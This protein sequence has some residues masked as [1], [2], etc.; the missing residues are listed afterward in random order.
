MKK[1][2]LIFAA[3]VLVYC[4][5]EISD[6]EK[7]AKLYVDMVFAREKFIYNDS[8]YQAEKLGVLKKYKITEEEYLNSLHELKYEDER[9]AEFFTKAKTYVDTLESIN[10]RQK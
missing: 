3:V 4:K 10:N 7:L 6:D 9:W 2:L 8:L 1:I 5:H